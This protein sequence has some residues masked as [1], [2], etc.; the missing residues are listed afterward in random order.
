[1]PWMWSACGVRVEHAIELADPGCKRLLA[2]IRAGIDQHIGEMSPPLEIRCASS[3]QRR[4][5][6]FGFFGI[7]DAPVA[8]NPRHAWRRAAAKH[9]ETI[10]AAQAGLCDRGTLENRRKK[11]S[12]VSAAISSRAD[13][14]HLRQHVRRVDDKRRLVALSAVRRRGEIGR[15]G[16]DQDPIRWNIARYVFDFLR[17]LER[18]DA[19]KRD[20]MAKCNSGLGQCSA[21]GKAVQNRR[22]SP[23]L[24]FALQDRGKV[25]VRLPRMDDERQAGRTR[26]R[27]VS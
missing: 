11:L 12:V 15:V 20:I 2:Q 25:G 19:R 4:R 9:G 17:I 23:L 24:H 27:D 21:G 16:L 26:R 6:F 7:A 22:K 3:E 18:Q 10:E 13:A 5:R 8:A 14:T 1:M